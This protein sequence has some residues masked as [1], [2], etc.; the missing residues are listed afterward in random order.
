MRVSTSQIYTI[1][2]IGMRDAQAAINK[3]NS[4]MASGQRVLTPADDPVAATQIMQLTQQLARL[5]QFN[6][7]IDVA[8]NKLS[9]EEVALDSIT[10][11]VQGMQELAVSA[12]NTATLTPSEYKMMA[13][14]VDSRI[15]ELLN[16]QNTKDSSGQHIFAGYQSAQPAYAEQG[17]AVAYQGDDGSVSLQVSESVTIQASDP[18]RKIFEGISTSH[19]TFSAY[20]LTATSEVTGFTV[21]DQDALDQMVPGTLKISVAGGVISV[22]DNNGNSVPPIPASQPNTAPIEIAGI[23]MSLADGDTLALNIKPEES[24]IMQTLTNFRDA[25]LNAANVTDAELSGVIDKTL[26]TLNNAVTRI[27]EVQAE[28]GARL[29]TLESTKN[30]N[31]DSALYTQEVLGSL[32]DL[33]YAEATT[34]LQMQ[35]LVLSAAQQSF[36]K[37][38]KLTLFNYL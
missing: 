27:G 22:T 36:A 38:S 12:G 16:L 2:N 1:A 31:A 8:E 9:L 18:G 7:N 34:R 5:E 30:L 26:G 28:V 21:A 14:E 24:S 25:M 17:G 29:N 11:L 32:Q 6:K 20:D 19:N 33:D 13:A 10:S 4:Q 35:E 3:T 23:S 15:K 37:V